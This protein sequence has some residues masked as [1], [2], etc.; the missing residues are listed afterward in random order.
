M[1]LEAAC[2]EYIAWMGR[3]RKS[4]LSAKSY[5]ETLSSFLEDGYIVISDETVLAYLNKPWKEST[6]AKKVAHFRAFAS[7]VFRKPSFRTLGLIEDFTLQQ[8]RPDVSLPEVVDSAVLSRFLARLEQENRYV[9]AWSMILVNTGM[10]FNEVWSLREGHL[11][12][13]EPSVPAL[14]FRGKRNTERMVPISPETLAC[15][16]IWTGQEKFVNP[17]Q[18]R[19]TWKRIQ[20]EIGA[21]PFFPSSLRVSSGTRRRRNGSRKGPPLTT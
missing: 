7:W 9:W 2:V 13:P 8:H 16:K 5:S 10:R 18:I 14:V 6:K 11:K 17:L 21:D 20:V 3:N 12:Y 1:N 19:K 15:F 4:R